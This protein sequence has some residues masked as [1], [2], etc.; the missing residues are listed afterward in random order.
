MVLILERGWVIV[1]LDGYW[2]LMNLCFYWLLSLS[3]WLALK[4]VLSSGVGWLL[5]VSLFFVDFLCLFQLNTVF[6]YFFVYLLFLFFRLFHF[7]FFNTHIVIFLLFFLLL[8]FLLLVIII[9]VI[10]ILQSVFGFSFLHS[11]NHRF[12]KASDLSYLKLTYLEGQRFEMKISF[13]EFKNALVTDL[14]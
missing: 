5:G 11:L 9:I 3:L 14:V 4:S 6:L 13:S 8:L 1:V 10:I 2:R 7:W 12:W